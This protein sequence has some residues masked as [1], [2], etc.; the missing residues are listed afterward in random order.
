MIPYFQWTE[1][2]VGPVRIYVWGLFVALG[3][4]VAVGAALRVTAKQGVDKEK[5]FDLSIW[6]IFWGLIGSRALYVVSEW[7]YFAQQ[8]FQAF[9]VW[10]G[11]MSLTGGIL[12]G[13]GYLWYALRDDKKLFLQYLEIVALVC[14]VGMMIGR[15]GCFCIYDHPGKSTDL[16]W[17]QEYSDGVVRHNHGLYL[18]IHAG[19]IALIFWWLYKRNTKRVPGFYISLFLLLYAAPR[20]F[21]DFWRATDL[22]GSDPRWYGLT[23]AQ[24]VSLVMIAAGIVLWY[25]VIHGKASKTARS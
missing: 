23:I 24:Y 8:P 4:V 9:A 2:F 13:V 6:I 10:N 3:L 5:I 15:V 12:G 19:I 25:T 14:P 22:T 17:G 1:F 21:L 16:P 20:F 11:G 7:Q 18:S